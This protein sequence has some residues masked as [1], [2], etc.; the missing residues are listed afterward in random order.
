VVQ[1][2]RFP[3]WVF[4]ALCGALPGIAAAQGTGAPGREAPRESGQHEGTQR[5]WGRAPDGERGFGSG[6]GVR[7]LAHLLR[8]TVEED[9][10]FVASLYDLERQIRVL[11][12]MTTEQ[13]KSARYFDLVEIAAKE[14]RPAT[15]VA[16]EKR[17]PLE[18]LGALFR[19]RA[20]HA[21]AALQQGGPAADLF[22]R[23]LVDTRFRVRAL[24]LDGLEFEIADMRAGLA[25]LF[26]ELD[27]FTG[28]KDGEAAAIADRVD[29]A[30]SRLRAAKLDLEVLREDGKDGKILPT[31][32]KDLEGLFELIRSDDAER[33][34]RELPEALARLEEREQS[35]SS[36]LFTIRLET[37]LSAEFEK[38]RKD[39][40]T[41][42]DLVPVVRALLLGSTGSEKPD[43]RVAHLS[44]NQR[45]SEG[46]RRA[47]EA[48]AC[49]PL[50]EE[51][52]W[53]QGEAS[54]FLQGAM[55]SRRFFDRYLAL[56]GIR[57][58]DHR[59][60]K[61]RALTHEEKRAIEVVQSAGTTQPGSPGS[62]GSPGPPAQPK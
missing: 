7:D 8:S 25:V 48:L 23:L 49:D 2:P 42:A 52:N 19:E 45:F 14:K 61:D 51:V 3:G 56:R 47:T 54:D 15:G 17:V 58:H 9:R 40:T 26:A 1:S 50:E 12:S 11:L 59:T 28:L 27:G 6:R 24:V 62:P 57:V 44:K 39:L 41:A 20:V 36:A 43:P 10:G 16:E 46:S 35:M 34:A 31:W 32:G 18:E 33:R 60:Y 22:A 4:L 13:Y 38:R 30:A 29:L 21:A 53:L 37:R 5:E 55:E